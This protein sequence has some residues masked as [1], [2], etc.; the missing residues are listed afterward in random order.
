MQSPFI[1]V[2]PESHP[3]ACVAEVQPRLGKALKLFEVLL[4]VHMTE[5]LNTLIA[6]F[7]VLASERS[8]NISQVERSAVSSN[9]EGCSS[10]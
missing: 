10:A 6:L 8:I 9:S 7:T 2:W 3:E 5:T 1:E 4:S